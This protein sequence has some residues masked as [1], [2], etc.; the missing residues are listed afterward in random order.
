M[1]FVAGDAKTQREAMNDSVKAYAK[2]WTGDELPTDPCLS[3]VEDV[4]ETSESSE[5]PT[6]VLITCQDYGQAIALPCYKLARPNV[7]FSTQI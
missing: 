4:T 1:H 3:T 2:Q 6:K 7:D 5:S